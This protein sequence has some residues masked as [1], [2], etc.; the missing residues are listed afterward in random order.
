MTFIDQLAD[1]ARR[2]IE[3]GVQET[4]RRRVRRL[5]D[6]VDTSNPIFDDVDKWL[7]ETQQLGEYLNGRSEK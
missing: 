4:P 6:P 3:R 5:T 7:R 1:M 2:Q